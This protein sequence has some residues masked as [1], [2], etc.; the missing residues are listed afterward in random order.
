MALS[1]CQSMVFSAVSQREA[2][3]MRG[4]LSMF[5]VRLLCLAVRFGRADRSDTSNIR[6][7]SIYWAK[8][9]CPPLARSADPPRTTRS[10]P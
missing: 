8:A 10:G 3:M 1:C 2:N 9:A 4:W 7:V 6:P 5:A